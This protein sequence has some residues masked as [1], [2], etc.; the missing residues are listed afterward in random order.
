MIIGFK[1]RLK[2]GKLSDVFDPSTKISELEAIARRQDDTR[3][4]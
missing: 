1:K 3:R 4:I 2:I